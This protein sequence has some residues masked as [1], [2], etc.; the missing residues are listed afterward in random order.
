[1]DEAK[2]TQQEIEEGRSAAILAYIP[3]LCFVPLFKW[4]DNRYAY[5]HARQGLAIF[6]IE[7][8]ALILLI[9]GLAVLLVKVVLTVAIIFALIGIAFVLQDK[10]WKIPYLGDWIDRK[11]KERFREE[12]EPFS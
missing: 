2:F 10:E 3:F 12:E 4:K 6:I 9:P 7:L 5:S 11:V 1:M 8:I